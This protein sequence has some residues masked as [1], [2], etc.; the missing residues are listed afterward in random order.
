MYHI[1]S[2]NLSNNSANIV[3]VIVVIV[4]NII[5]IIVSSTEDKQFYVRYRL[6]NW[7]TALAEFSKPEFSVVRQH[8][9]F[10]WLH[11]RF[12]ENEDYAGIVVS[13][14]VGRFLFL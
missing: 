2:S 1:H 12:E 9:E 6:C 3:L 5:I 8:E 11:D 7:Q 14:A 4:A 10:I 13:I